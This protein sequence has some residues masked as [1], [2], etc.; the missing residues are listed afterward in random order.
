MIDFKMLKIVLA[1][2]TSALVLGECVV[3]TPLKYGRLK[4]VAMDVF[5]QIINEPNVE[6]SNNVG[7]VGETGPGS[8][9]I[10]VSYGEYR[11]RVSQTGFRSTL[12]DI[13]IYQP[14]TEVRVELVVGEECGS[15]PASIG[16]TIK[17]DRSGE[18]WVKAIPVR[19]TGDIES[20]VRDSGHFLISG[21]E[22]S[23]YVLVVIQRATVL[24]HQVV[25][26][27][28][29]DDILNVSID[30]RKTH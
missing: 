22:S 24:H 11:L 6:L 30:L 29:R 8:G 12:K 1:L 28:V 25:Q 9:L 21:L 23:A 15:R 26:M 13:K 17:V 14:D 2:F 20:R 3:T 5:G 16:G 18:L 27:P 19:G 7:R 4:V 10:R